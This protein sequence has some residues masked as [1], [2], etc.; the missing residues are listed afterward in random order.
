MTSGRSGGSGTSES[1]IL[2]SVTPVRA[3]RG[4]RNCRTVEQF[5]RRLCKFAR[6][7]TKRMCCVAQC[8]NY[9]GKALL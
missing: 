7:L 6:L 1:K 4:H 9:L 8:A 3:I 2:S 5:R